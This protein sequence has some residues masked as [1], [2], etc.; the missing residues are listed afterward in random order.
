MRTANDRLEQAQT[1]GRLLTR[2]PY[3]TRPNTKGL[4][5]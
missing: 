2:V 5:G 4:A 1:P 3:W